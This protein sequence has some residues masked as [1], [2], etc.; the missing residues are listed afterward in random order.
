MANPISKQLTATAVL[1]QTGPCA[2]EALWAVNEA[3]AESFIQF[4]DAA[5]VGDVTVG[6]TANRFAL[7]L[8]ASG[9]GVV[10]LP[11]KINFQKGLVAASTTTA[12]GNS[13]ATVDAL[14]HMA[15]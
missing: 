8:P 15:V 4:F 2:L 9:G 7:P 1:V 10:P 13:T 12:S 14:F 11:S 5:Q 6:T 3:A